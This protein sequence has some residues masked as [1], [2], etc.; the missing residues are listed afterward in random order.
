MSDTRNVVF[1]E[2][3]TFDFRKH[4][5]FQFGNIRCPFCD[6]TGKVPRHS[7]YLGIGPDDMENCQTCE[8]IGKLR[9]YVQIGWLPDKKS[10]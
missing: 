10:L 5:E 7:D 1:I 4:E 8:G 3:K 9:A 6:G 2:P